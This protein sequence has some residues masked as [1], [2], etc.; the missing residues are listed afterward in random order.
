MNIKPLGNRLVVQLLKQK[1]TTASGI[2]LSTEEK[3]EQSLGTVIAL[4]V[5]YGQ[6]NVQNLGVKKGDKVLF[7]KYSGEEVK[8]DQEPDD[9]YKIL[10][11]DDVL[12]VIED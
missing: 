9:V 2:I 8:D 3:N 12:A 5:G 10:K 6:N 4:G 11:V 1:N 7:S